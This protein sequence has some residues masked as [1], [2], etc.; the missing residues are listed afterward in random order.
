MPGFLGVPQKPFSSVAGGTSGGSPGR[1][2]RSQSAPTIPQ[3]RL[4]VRQRTP[5]GAPRAGA[6]FGVSV[7]GELFCWR[8]LARW[9]FN[10]LT[11]L[12]ADA[13]AVGLDALANLPAQLTDLAFEHRSKSNIVAV[14]AAICA[15]RSAWRA[16]KK[17]SIFAPHLDDGGALVD[18]L[19][20]DDLGEPAVGV[21]VG[22]QADHARGVTLQAVSGKRYDMGRFPAMSAGY[23]S[24]GMPHMWAGVPVDQS[25]SGALRG[26]SWCLQWLSAWWPPECDASQASHPSRARIGNEGLRALSMNL[27]AGSSPAAFFVRQGVDL[28]Q[29]C[30]FYVLAL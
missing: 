15:V 28:G 18:R 23:T 20:A 12:F 30:G 26:R 29:R 6:F 14:P 19:L 17:R 1:G 4:V 21:V 27:A 7:I 11:R 13:L 5:L 8:R 25:G 3:L 10:P 22:F 2:G 24:E 16:R 9:R